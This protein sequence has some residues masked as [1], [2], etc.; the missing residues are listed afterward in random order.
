MLT[1]SFATYVA[2][3]RHIQHAAPHH[4]AHLTL[5]NRFWPFAATCLATEALH[6][7]WGPK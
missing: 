5:N 1:A 2:S 7:S 3:T 4:A 6:P